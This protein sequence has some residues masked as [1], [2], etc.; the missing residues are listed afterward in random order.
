MAKVKFKELFYVFHTN[1]SGTPLYLTLF[2]IFFWFVYVADS[3]AIHMS[4]GI[5]MPSDKQY[6]L[7]KK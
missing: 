1:T 7:C 5:T 2:V 6:L 3:T 4:N